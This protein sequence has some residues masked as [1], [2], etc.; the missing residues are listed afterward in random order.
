LLNP[1]VMKMKYVFISACQ[2]IHQNLKRRFSFHSRNCH[3]S[4][5]FFFF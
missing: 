2:L 5:F 1:F 4:L 3:A